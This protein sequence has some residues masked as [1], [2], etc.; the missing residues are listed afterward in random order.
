MTYIV[1]L[2]VLILPVSC[3]KSTA[4]DEYGFAMMLGTR[5]GEDNGSDKPCF[6]IWEQKDYT[7]AGFGANPA[8]PYAVCRPDGVIGAYETA[9][10]NTR[11]VYPLHNELAYAVGVSPGTIVSASQSGWKTLDIAPALAGVADIQTAKAITGSEQ[12]PFDTPLVFNHLLTRLKFYGYCHSD[13]HESDNEKID[14]KKVEVSIS[15]ENQW[16]RLP[17]E[18]EW[19]H[20]HSSGRYTVNGYS[21][22]PSPKVVATVKME[23]GVVIDSQDGSGDAKFVGNLYLMPGFEE[24][25]VDIKATYV[26]YTTDGPAPGGNG[27]EQVL[28]WKNV[29]IPGIANSGAPTSAGESY[30]LHLVFYRSTIKIGV[31]LNPWG[32][33]IEN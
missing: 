12:A 22:A 11:H 5:A 15:S 16:L 20:D 3:K 10:Y 31:T 19:E 25:A 14:V 21:A 1:W 9:K 2:V 7:H 30:K 6:I 17:K 29:T 28:E 18:L 8:V 27:R 13:M 24:I 33:D 4:D 32:P 26:D 23:D